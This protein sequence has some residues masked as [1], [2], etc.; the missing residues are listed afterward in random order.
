VADR[1]ATPI[2]IYIAAENP[3]RRAGAL[4]GEHHDDE[5]LARQRDQRADGLAAAERLG[6]VDRRGVRAIRVSV[7]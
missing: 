2:A 6:G 3:G 1:L 5:R 4:V 7:R